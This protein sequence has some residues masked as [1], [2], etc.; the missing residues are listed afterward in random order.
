VSFLRPV[1]AGTVVATGEAVR[2]S[3]SV[4]VGASRLVDESGVELGRGQGD[5][6]R[7]KKPWSTLALGGA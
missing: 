1:A 4:C 3:S 6:C 5:F 2:I 7:A